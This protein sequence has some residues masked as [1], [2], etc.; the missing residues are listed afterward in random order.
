[1]SEKELIQALRAL[2]DQHTPPAPEPRLLA[3]EIV[4]RDA[5]R[6]RILAGL[7]IL[8]WIAGI[9]GIFIVFFSLRWYLILSSSVIESLV[10]DPVLGTDIF[11]WERAVNRSLEVSMGCLGAW[12]LGSLCTT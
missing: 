12:M 4:R 3:Q 10:I 6:L 9:A 7:S 8:F 2:I 1:M 11:S 5:W